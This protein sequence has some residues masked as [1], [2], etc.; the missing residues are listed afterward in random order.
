[1]DETPKHLPDSGIILGK[2]RNG[3]ILSVDVRQKT[4]DR[5]LHTYVIG[6]TDAGKS[7]FL[8][9][10]MIQDIKNGQGVCFIDP[11]GDL[12]NEILDYIPQER[13]KDVVYFNPADPKYTLSFN[14]LESSS[15]KQMDQTFIIDEI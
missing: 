13:I 12:A 8:K 10:M 11:L 4:E 5:R 3:S 1:M 7:I 2:G 15:E 14:I 6:Q 9:N